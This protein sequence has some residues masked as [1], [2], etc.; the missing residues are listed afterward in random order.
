M[1]SKLVFARSACYFDRA[2]YGVHITCPHEGCRSVTALGANFFEV[3]LVGST[4]VLVARVC[5]C[6]DRRA[7]A[8]KQNKSMGHGA[9][10][11]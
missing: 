8:I 10:A 7:A 5:M 4:I 3:Y 6:G 9:A 2:C 1:L 11:G